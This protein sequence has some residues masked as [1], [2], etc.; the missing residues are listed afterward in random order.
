MLAEAAHYVA[1]ETIVPHGYALDTKF[2]N[3][4]SQLEGR[5]VA[6]W[7]PQEYGKGGYSDG[8]CVGRITKVE[9]QIADAYQELIAEIED[10]GD[11]NYHTITKNQ[12]E[13][14]AYYECDKSVG[15]SI[16]SLAE[17]GSTWH[18]LENHLLA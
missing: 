4:H 14:H 5:L 11:V 12:F 16:V 18:L 6:T 3:P 15:T 2:P 10:D 1:V 13:I 8:W 9:G 17:Y 7:W